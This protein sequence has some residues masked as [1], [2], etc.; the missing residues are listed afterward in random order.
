MWEVG[1]Q[2]SEHRGVAGSSPAPEDGRE[3]D[4][5]DTDEPS[6]DLP[7]SLDGTNGMMDPRA[8]DTSRVRTGVY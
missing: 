2:G 1:S 8:L 3:D 5:M 7:D 6:W 4:V